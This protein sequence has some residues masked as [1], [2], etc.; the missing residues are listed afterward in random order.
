MEKHDELQRQ[1]SAAL[2][3]IRVKAPFFFALALFARISFS[4]RIPTAATNG[5]DIF[6]NE[7]FWR[8]LQ[9]RERLGLMVHEVLHAALLHVQR[10]GTREPLLWNIAADVVVNGMI[11]AQE[12]FALP[13]GHVRDTSL[14][15][16]SVEE[17]YHLLQKQAEKYR[18]FQFSDLL[19]DEGIGSDTD[20]GSAALSQYWR[21]ALQHARTMQEMMGGQG[22]LPAGLEREM[23]GFNPAQ[24]DW[25]SYLWR[26]L[27]QTPTDFQGFDRRFIG[28][29]LYLE[30][31]D[32]ESV[33]VYVAVD[34]S[35]SIGQQ[36]LSLF[37]GEVVG[38]LNAYPHIVA[39]LYYVDAECYGPYPLTA[40]DEIPPPRGGGGTDF[41]PFFT[42]IEKEAFDPLAAVCV[43]LTDG[44]GTFPENL[45]TL[46][47]LWVLT[48]GG[49]GVEEVPFGEAVRLI[50]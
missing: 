5:R 40:F 38:I 22:T 8:N 25:R 4:A 46:P 35:G 19:D 37:L 32:G 34:T 36:E 24:L 15:H 45:F 18:D 42:A 31:L 48:P 44:Y 6:I 17:I 1:I 47:V 2:L 16:L 39:S 23:A 7:A 20:Q 28:Q 3:Q 14:E 12:G 30:A 33:R 50:L 9:P 43:Y 10:R 11:L 29:G 13:D 21:H 49:I 27:V 41:R 26:F